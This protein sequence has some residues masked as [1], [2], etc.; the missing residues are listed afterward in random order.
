[1]REGLRYKY[2]QNPTLFMMLFLTGKAKLIEDAPWDDYFGTGKNGKG[3]NVM[4]KL[5]EELR[6]SPPD[7]TEYGV[8]ADCSAEDL[9]VYRGE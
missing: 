5:L 9:K 6:T 7:V 4:G 1:M 8:P 2:A 3:K